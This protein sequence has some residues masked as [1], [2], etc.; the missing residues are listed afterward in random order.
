MKIREK[1]NKEAGELC[2][3]TGIKA[4]SS[5]RS[6]PLFFRVFT[7]YNASSRNCGNFFTRNSLRK[8]LQFGLLIQPKIGCDPESSFFY[9]GEGDD[10]LCEHCQIREES[11]NETWILQQS[12]VEQRGFLKRDWFKKLSMNVSMGFRCGMLSAA[13]LILTSSFSCAIGAEMPVSFNS[14]NCIKA[15]VGEVEGESYQTKLATAEA[16]RN[17]GSLKGVYGINSKRISKASRKVWEECTLSWGESAHSNLVRGATVWG[18][19][20]DVEHFRKTRWFKSYVQT[21][22]IG[23]HFF[24]KEIKK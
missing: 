24:F 9:L 12:S 2:V 8:N 4:D 23:N 7:A 6:R 19:K 10:S 20:K 18:N 3:C 1:K 13:M 22:H 21:A 15:L 11:K 17:R 16:L 5:G 14:C